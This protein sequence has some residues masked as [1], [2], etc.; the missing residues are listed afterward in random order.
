MYLKKPPEK[1]ENKYGA[2]MVADVDPYLARP[3]K[4]VFAVHVSGLY[5]RV[6]LSPGKLSVKFAPPNM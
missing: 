4:S 6:S 1:P 5:S 3:G 2:P